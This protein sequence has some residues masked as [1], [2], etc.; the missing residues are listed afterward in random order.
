MWPPAQSAA[1]RWKCGTPCHG[2]PLSADTPRGSVS[3]RSGTKGVRSCRTQ[4][5]FCMALTP[6]YRR[7]PQGL[8]EEDTRDTAV[9]SCRVPRACADADGPPAYTCCVRSTVVL[10]AVVTACACYCVTLRT[11]HYVLCVQVHAI[12]FPL[13]HHPPRAQQ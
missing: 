9:H 8:P 1:V 13:F 3:G 6:K 11:C 7:L 5:P 4:Q 12:F 10:R 2:I